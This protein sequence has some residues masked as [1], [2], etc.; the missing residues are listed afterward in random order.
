LLS[1]SKS[2]IEW[3]KDDTVYLSVP[4]TWDLPE[5][6]RKAIQASFL[7]YKVKAGG[8]A[9]A[10]MPGYLS[11]VAECNGEQVPALWK[12]NP[13]ATF[14]SRGCIR[15][16]PFCA[17]PKIEGQLREL[18]TWPVR[19]IVCDNNLLA[20]S[21]AHFDKVID[22]LKIYDGF[23]RKYPALPQIDFNQGLDSRLL[24]DHHAKRL[25]E[26]NCIVR[27]AF[28]S[29]EYERSFIMAFVS[30]RAAGIP[31]SRI[32]A[33]VLIGFNDTP[34]DALYRLNVVQNLGIDPNP[35]RYQ[36]LDVL[37]KNSYV[38]PNWTEAE[39]ARYMRYWSR[40][41]FFRAVPFED[42]DNSR[43]SIKVPEGQPVLFD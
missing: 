19:P 35:M 33:Y 25:A 2:V 43:Q 21:R 29:I 14:T 39:L 30:L 40:L 42:F 1:W 7:G 27:L 36:P 9:V 24:T 31:K 26:L 13:W 10:M 20:C 6:R 3:T 8:P 11:D 12:H 23:R 18:D 28:D 32:R 15:K 34:F 4:F 17:V 41:R 16:C 38:A 22:R 5:A 37:E